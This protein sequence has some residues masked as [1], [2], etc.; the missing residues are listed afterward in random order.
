MS[1]GKGRPSFK[2]LKLYYDMF[3]RCYDKLL[4]IDIDCM[5][6]EFVS[7]LD[8]IV[9]LTTILVNNS[10]IDVSDV[11]YDDGIKRLDVLMD[12]V[13]KL[14]ASKWNGLD[15]SFKEFLE[16]KKEEFSNL[17]KGLIEEFKLDEKSRPAG[18]AVS[19]FEFGF[20]YDFKQ[21][22]E[23]MKRLYSSS[24]FEKNPDEFN[25]FVCA[26]MMFKIKFEAFLETISYNEEVD[27]INDKLIGFMREMSSFFGTIT[28]Y[29]GIE[30][31]IAVL[32]SAY[33]TY[34]DKYG[35]T[36]ALIDK[37]NTSLKDLRGSLEG[38]N[39][40]LSKADKNSRGEVDWTSI[41]EG[42]SNELS[43]VYKRACQYVA[44]LT[45][46]DVDAYLN[47]KLDAILADINEQNRIAFDLQKNGLNISYDELVSIYRKNV[48]VKACLLGVVCNIYMLSNDEQKSTLSSFFDLNHDNYAW[49]KPDFGYGFD[50]YVKA[51]KLTGEIPLAQRFY[52]EFYRTAL[53]EVIEGQRC[54]ILNGEF[55]ERF[56]TSCEQLLKKSNTVDNSFD[57]LSLLSRLSGNPINKKYSDFSDA[58][59]DSFIGG[60][61]SSFE[62]LNAK[63]KQAF[64]LLRSFEKEFVLFNQLSSY[65]NNKQD[66]PRS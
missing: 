27:K 24:S 2:E 5:S 52:L 35:E 21:K 53:F 25:S 10:S 28:F 26:V 31:S 42:H 11:I 18:D 30:N 58:S 33:K 41:F 7:I 12:D 46:V 17:Y 44:D 63:L 1:R 40:K 23:E 19:G 29:R 47:G 43:P 32:D 34:K 13:N 49:F 55:K 9:T 66:R 59:G 45:V 57:I 16:S 54:F 38:F 20:D 61:G 36:G 4:V 37:Y 22:V 15:V 62:T 50:E 65:D 39:F 6:E 14:F 51:F 64:K 56:L 60:L 48:N 8:S 3:C